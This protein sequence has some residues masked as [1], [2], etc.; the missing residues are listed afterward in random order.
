VFSISFSL[1]S[2]VSFSLAGTENDGE[3][4]PD[5]RSRS[6]SER[7]GDWD[8]YSRLGRPLSVPGSK[9]RQ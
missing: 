3:D 8:S 9:D 2:L 1:S 6:L 4:D 7:E 5:P